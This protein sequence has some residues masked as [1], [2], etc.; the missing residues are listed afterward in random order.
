MFIWV[1]FISHNYKIYLPLL[2]QEC[3][4]ARLFEV[5]IEDDCVIQ[6]VCDG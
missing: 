3:Q 6:R 2:W 1:L 4:R 5:L